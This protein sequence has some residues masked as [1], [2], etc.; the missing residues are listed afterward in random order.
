MTYAM[1][2][3]IFLVIQVALVTYQ[4]PLLAPREGGGGKGPPRPRLQAPP[5]PCEQEVGRGFRA[6]AG[7]PQGARARE[8]EEEEAQLLAWSPHVPRPQ[9]FVRRCARLH[10]AASSPGGALPWSRTLACCAGP[11]TRRT[12]MRSRLT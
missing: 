9:A 7:G 4:G 3:S 2:S 12:T 6:L 8:E 10:G 11:A 1:A 5:P